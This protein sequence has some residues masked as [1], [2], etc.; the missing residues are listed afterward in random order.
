M[1]LISTGLYNT[2]FWL[3]LYC[4]TCFWLVLYYTIH[5]SDQY[6]T[7]QYMFLIS[8]VLCNPGVNIIPKKANFLDP[9]IIF[10][11]QFLKK[12]PPVKIFFQIPLTHLP[13]CPQF[14]KKCPNFWKKCPHFFFKLSFKKILPPIKQFAPISF[15][16]LN[17]I[18]PCY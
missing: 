13:H 8:T 7:I 6:W 10:C 4:N 5:V 15:K 3:V 1:F 12:M 17:Y 14:E 9:K 16:F 2:C 18:D 11:P